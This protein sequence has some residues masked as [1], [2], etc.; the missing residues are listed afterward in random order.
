[1]SEPCAVCGHPPDPACGRPACP[2]AGAGGL[3]PRRRSAVG[4]AD[5]RRRLL[6]SGPELLLLLGLEVAAAPFVP[7][8]IGVSL[9]IA[10]WFS[11]RDLVGGALNPGKRIAGVRLVDAET[12]RVPSHRQAVLRNLPYILG[13]L[14]AAVPGFEVV[15]WA[16]LAA[17][18]FLD[19][20]LVLADP[21][22]RRLGDRIAGT[23]VVP[24]HPDG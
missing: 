8:G 24:G 23:K 2:Q 14:V 7:V 12:G 21:L 16:F 22:G 11:V 1:M 6:A 9:A 19:L 5:P 13:W 3:A 18:G 17:A 20:G 4:R 10:L 15:G